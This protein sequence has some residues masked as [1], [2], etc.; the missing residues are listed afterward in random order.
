MCVDI[1]GDCNNDNDVSGHANTYAGT[2]DEA[3]S[4]DNKESAIRQ[5]I[6]TISNIIGA[7]TVEVIAEI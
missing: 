6:T 2:D 5:M 3:K 7:A 1:N 4:I